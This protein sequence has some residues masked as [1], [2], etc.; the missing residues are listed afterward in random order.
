MYNFVP[1]SSCCVSE[2]IKGSVVW[3]GGT[4]E[5]SEGVWE[6]TD[7]SPWGYEN[8]LKRDEPHKSEPTNFRGNEDC[9]VIWGREWFDVNCEGFSWMKGAGYVCSYYSNGK[10]FSLCFF[11]ADSMPL[12]G[13]NSYNTVIRII[14]FIK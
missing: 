9:T 1:Y 6:W 14:L 5:R 2:N 13:S 4:D 8:W 7:G 10:K 3:I 11:T 12:F